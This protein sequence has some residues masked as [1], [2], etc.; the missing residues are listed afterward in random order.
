MIATREFLLRARIDAETL[1]TWVEAGWLRTPAQ[2]E[3]ERF[4]DIDL[5][6]ARLIRDLQQDMRVNTEGITIILD[7]VD[8]V[9]GLR[10]TL[11]ELLSAIYARSEAIRRRLATEPLKAADLDPGGHAPDPRPPPGPGMDGAG[12]PQ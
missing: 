1:E 5:A 12:R 11:R 3:A 7:L 9:H 2:G 4:A 10:R 6:R 8:Q